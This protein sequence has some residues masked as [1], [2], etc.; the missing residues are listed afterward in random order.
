MSQP[1][2]PLDKLERALSALW[3]E[4]PE[5]VA[6][7]FTKIVRA[8]LTAATDKARREERDA[9]AAIAR[10]HQA[11]STLRAILDRALTLQSPGDAAPRQEGEPKT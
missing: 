11:P 2:E 7:D 6:R 4:L 10:E 9:C 8:A 3:L 5:A 1:Q